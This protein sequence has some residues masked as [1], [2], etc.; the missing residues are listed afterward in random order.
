MQGAV[1][2]SALGRWVAS[3]DSMHPAD[4]QIHVRHGPPISVWAFQSAQK[5]EFLTETGRIKPVWVARLL[6]PSD[7][8]APAS[9]SWTH[10]ALLWKAS[11][12]GCRARGELPHPS[13]YSSACANEARSPWCSACCPCRMSVVIL[14][15]EF[16]RLGFKGRTIDYR[17][18]WKVP[19]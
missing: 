1:R 12:G 9:G 8:R 13:S 4:V 16:L 19:S 5:G 15:T 17:V 6:G 7:A 3:S 10:Q 2:A 14:C 11:G 18:N